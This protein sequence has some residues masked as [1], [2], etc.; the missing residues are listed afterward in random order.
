MESLEPGVTAYLT[1]DLPAGHYGYVST[2][3][4]GK[5]FLAGLHGEFEVA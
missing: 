4:E 2:A 1:I 3:G 5:D